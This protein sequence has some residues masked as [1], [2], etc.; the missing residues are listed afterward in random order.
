M[1]EL[2]NVDKISQKSSESLKS[3]VKAYIELK[4]D[5]L[6]SQGIDEKVRQEWIQLS[7]VIDVGML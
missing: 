1:F 7:H 5:Q 4:A 2:G 3:L 6:K